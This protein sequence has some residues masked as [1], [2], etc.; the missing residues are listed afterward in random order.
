MAPE[1]QVGHGGGEQGE[2]PTPVTGR[3]AGQKPREMDQH[4]DPA[5]QILCSP[6]I[7]ADSII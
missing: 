6:V 5:W 3:A 2:A 4:S 1:A 7:S